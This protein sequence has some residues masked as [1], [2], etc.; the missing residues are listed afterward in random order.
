MIIDNRQHGRVGD[1]LK[2][3]L[4]ADIKLS[5][6]TNRFYHEHLYKLYADII[7]RITASQSACITDR[8][9]IADNAEHKREL[10]NVIEKL[11]SQ[12]DE[13]RNR[14]KEESQ[15]NEKVQ[16]NMELKKLEEQV[17]AKQKSLGE[18]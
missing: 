6:L 10:L 11:Q 4:S 14:L 13:L 8:F 9:S 18:L 15:F 2:G 1:V 17:E 7:S 12:V 16:L 3:H 5:L